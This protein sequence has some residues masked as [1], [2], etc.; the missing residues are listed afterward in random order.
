MRE[1]CHAVTLDASRDGY[2]VLRAVR[3]GDTVVD[4]II[5][6]ANELVR[7]R[8]R[9]VVGDVVGKPL[10][11]LE[12]AADNRPLWALYGAALDTGERQETDFE[13]TLPAGMGGWRRAIAVPVD[14]ETVTVVT[15]DITRERYFEKELER[16]RRTLTGL[17]AARHGAAG[18]SDPRISEPR[19]VSRSAAFLF[20]GAG[21]VTIA[22]SLLAA[23]PG[24]DVPVL[25]ITAVISILTAFC[26]PLL[27]WDRHLRPVAGGLVLLAIG[28]LVVS[29]QFDHFSRSQSAVAVY[30]I[31][32]IMVVAWSGL[33]QVRGAPTVAA[34][35][36]GLALGGI[37]V[38][39]GHGSIGLQCVIVTMP[40]SAILGEVMAWSSRR[41]SDLVGLELDRRLHDPLTGLANR[42]LFIE[43]AEQ[44]LARVKRS[45]RSLAVLFIDLDRFKQVNDSM[46]HAAG[47]QLLVEASSRLR[48][49]V[50]QSDDVA[51]FGGDEFAVL[52]EDL[53]NEDGAVT[54]ADRVLSMLD[55]PFSLGKRDVSVGASIGIAFSTDGAKTAEA[56]LQ[57]ADAAMYRA[58]DAGRARFEFFDDAMQ[59]DIAARMELESAL[60][61]A[62][63]RNELR[64][65]YQPIVAAGT[66]TI[67][68]FEA[69]VRWDRP[70]FGLVAPGSFIGVA[71]ETGMIIDIG[72]WV[73]NEACR[74]AAAWMVQWPHRR[75]S[76]TVNISSRQVLKG[77]I[78]DIVHDAL[79]CS[80]LDPT[81]LTL[82][83]TETTLID[84]ALSAQAI[85]R[86]LRAFGVSIALDD[87]GTGYSSLTY[88]RTFPINVIKIDGSF[89][90]T[91]ETER[92]AAAIVS[93]VVSLA[94]SLDITVIAEGIESVEQL[95]A[96][97]GLNCTFLQGYLFSHP[98]PVEDLPALIDG[99]AIEVPC[100]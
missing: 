56:I 42:Q 73:L 4:W 71:E 72:S 31:F 94:E 45:D 28:F 23:H 9:R 26:V 54:I 3:Q 20:F 82:E 76:V 27:P 38:E 77:D 49:L 89:V 16:S 63:S 50:R 60:R 19:L 80:R 35:L 79:R 88:L 65:F 10:S 81:L 95:A 8:W 36:S 83:L 18:A 51:R 30:P 15:R 61:Q 22:N 25:R 86:E 34:C 58:K 46:G 70:G 17:A 33:I 93:T 64:V 53:D 41:V 84:D 47:D 91:I 98:K 55:E 96:V 57:D 7:D 6:D 59:R 43:R 44:A 1:H 39:G 29:D 97:V 14:H 67:V 85:L 99:W 32:F 69:L 68:G 13:L 2:S 62:V 100:R 12:A 75:L 66:H 37:L 21:V 78:V 5:T 48:E 24:V 74:Q 92:E 52:C 11:V 90:R 40:A 87:F